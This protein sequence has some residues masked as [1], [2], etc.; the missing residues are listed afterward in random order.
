MKDQR[1]DLYWRGRENLRQEGH[2]WN[3]PRPCNIYKTISKDQSYVSKS[4]YI[5]AYQDYFRYEADQIMR[6]DAVDR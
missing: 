2:I 1:A 4:I 3:D 6:T 5:K